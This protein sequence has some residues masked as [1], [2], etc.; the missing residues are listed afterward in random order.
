MKLKKIILIIIGAIILGVVI[1][2]INL[3][4]SNNKF[5]SS[6]NLTV[7]PAFSPTPTPKL[8]LPPIDQNS[9]LK[10][11]LNKLIPPDFSED[12]KNLRKELN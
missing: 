6:P 7:I 8:T 1:F 4:S 11:E 12:F 3:K 2:L 9:N 5:L 10:E